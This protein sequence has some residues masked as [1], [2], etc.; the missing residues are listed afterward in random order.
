[1]SYSPTQ[2]SSVTVIKIGGS[3]LGSQDTTLDDLVS[4][5]QRGVATVVVHGGGEVITSWLAKQGVATRFVRG[6]RV[7]EPESLAVATAVLAGLVNKELVADI[8]SKGGRAI[9]ISGVDGRL[10]EARTRDPELGYVG[11]ITKVNL[12]LVN[13]LLE[14]GYIPVVAP[15]AIFEVSP[16]E[17]PLLLNVN[18]DTVAG[19]LAA[20]LKAQLLI[21]L[22]DV[23][24]VMDV[25]GNVLP[26]L[27][28]E[29]ASALVADGA[30]S[31]GMI[32][33]IEAC[34]RALDGAA[35]TRILDGRVAHSLIT[36][37]E[38]A[39]IGTTIE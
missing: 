34:I 16:H 18:A 22:T 39:G 31:G 1:M 19:E 21:F 29:Q 15:I 17:G 4:L 6:L 26:H 13:T 20:E 35:T 23:A 7:T 33:K 27:S 28:T 8:G 30:A 24:G 5:Q 3:T 25:Q 38:N 36:G 9:G 11:E 10:L 14:A 37:I 32:P 12:G 2:S